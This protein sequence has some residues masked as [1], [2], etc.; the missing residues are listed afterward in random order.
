M[1]VHY[2]LIRADGPVELAVRCPDPIKNCTV[3]PIRRKVRTEIDGRNVKLSVGETEPRYFVVII[4]DYPPLVIL[5]DPIERELLDR[6]SRHVFDLA[7]VLTDSA[8]VADRTATFEQA[9]RKAAIDKR[10]AYVPA[11]VYP[12]GAIKVHGLQGLSVY[13]AAGSLLRTEVSPPGENV[14]RDGIWL[15]D[16]QNV[17][18]WG[19]G[20]LDHQAF[21]N[22]AHGR[23]AYNHGLVSYH[24]TKALCPFT[25]QSSVFM[26]R[27]RDVF[28]E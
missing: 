7:T 3:H 17:R 8:S 23:N 2:S 26:L 18:I 11:G 19:S 14:H 20:C 13:F 9:L 24:V 21:G 25:T 12:V 15:Q 10:T 6:E 22:Y 28:V 5:I 4:D 27:C 16:S 1:G